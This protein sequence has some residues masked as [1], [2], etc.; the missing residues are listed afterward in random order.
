M[1]AQGAAAVTTFSEESD[2]AV[3]RPF[4]AVRPSKEKAADVAALPYDVMTSAEARVMTKDAPLSFLHVD[5]AEID[6]PEGTDL[7]SD[8]VYEKAAANLRGLIDDGVLIRDPDRCYYLYR[9]IMDG[10]AQTGIVGCASIDE[11]ISGTIK[12]H[13]LTVAAKEADRI[14]HVDVC[15][16]NTGIIFLT[17]RNSPALEERM[18]SITGH[19]EPLY[20]F[21]AEDGVRHIVW[22]VGDPSDVRMFEESF[23]QIPALY[24]ADGHHRTASAVRV[25]EKRRREHPGYTGEEEFNYF[26]SVLFPQDQ[27]MILDYNR[28]VKDLGGRT[29][30]QFLEELDKT[31]EI[32]CE[33]STAV[34][35]SCKGEFGLCLCDGK[36]YRL[37]LRE[38]PDS[39]DPVSSLDVSVLQ[40]KVLGPLLGI[41][42]P[43]EDPRISFIGGIRG[44]EELERRIESGSDMAAFSM[45][46]TS[47]E[48]L[49]AVAD[50]GELMPPKSTW[51]EPKL[52]SGLFI[53]RL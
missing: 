19:D 50:A 33:G 4:C 36:W 1:P 5:R 14:R 13:E 49:F 32:K 40:D 20:D 48:E 38:M 39:S 18:E 43:K 21:V 28:A 37:K 51:F 34:K 17:F 3:F 6:L 26:L 27:L 22:K 46:P 31:F 15:N 30:Q 29:A 8:E 41:T 53:H 23:S 12:K 9:E 52:L 25:G 45:Y 7:Y 44:L 2:M 16:A 24:I 47:L 10:R 11:Y 35:P 42:D